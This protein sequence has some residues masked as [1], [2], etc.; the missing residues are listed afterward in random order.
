MPRGMAELTRKLKEK[1]KTKRA[2]STKS[3][4]VYRSGRA[5]DPAA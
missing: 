2:A 1:H 4:Q 5:G 3:G